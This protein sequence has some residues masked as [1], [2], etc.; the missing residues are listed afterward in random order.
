MGDQN[1]ICL[2]V[3]MKLR[4]LVAC[5]LVFVLVTAEG[6]FTSED[7]I[8]LESIKVSDAL[9]QELQDIDEVRIIEVPQNSHEPFMGQGNQK[10]VRTFT[11]MLYRK[12]GKGLGPGSFAQEKRREPVIITSDRD[13][14]MFVN[15]GAI[16]GMPHV[17][18]ARLPLSI[19]NNQQYEGRRW[20]AVPSI[21]HETKN[22]VVKLPPV[23]RVTPISGV[24]IN[25]IDSKAMST[26]LV[27][28]NSLQKSPT[29]NSSGDSKENASG[30]GQEPA[31]DSKNNSPL[32][33]KYR[34]QYVGDQQ[35]RA[36]KGYSESSN[37]SFVIPQRPPLQHLYRNQHLGVS[38]QPIPAAIMPPK[39]YQ[40][41]LRPVQGTTRPQL[42]NHSMALPAKVPRVTSSWI[43]VGKPLSPEDFMHM[44][45]LTAQPIR[46]TPKM[47]IRQL[48]GGTQDNIV[49]TT[50]NNE[51]F[52]QD[53]APLVPAP[54]AVAPVIALLSP[55]NLERGALRSVVPSKELHRN[56]GLLLDQ[57]RRYPSYF[58]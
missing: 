10:T 32:N 34:D 41:Y 23:I 3:R 36:Q 33:L 54:S 44:P 42:P 30:T 12:P 52:F 48:F 19:L 35:R 40:P 50:D 51:Q 56:A 14:M 16:L 4:G 27:R 49:I 15:L 8:N 46:R 6:A 45:T 57:K 58:G 1:C 37:N 28:L 20:V 11:G 17:G 9:L 25:S 13:Q 7:L 29:N 43:P 31:K 55:V 39:Y 53:D 18:I 26:Q 22:K 2:G 5:L 47:L 38:S 21:P 24:N